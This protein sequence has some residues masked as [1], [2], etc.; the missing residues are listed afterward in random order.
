MKPTRC[1]SNLAKSRRILGV[2]RKLSMPALLI[3]CTTELPFEPPPPATP[4]DPPA[5][6]HPILFSS[7]RDKSVSNALEVIAATA[8]GS[9][10]VN[11]SNHVAND[12][13]PVWSPDGQQIAF[14]SDRNGNYDIYLM[15]RDGS[16]VRQLT[17]D[18]M[19]ERYPAWSPDGTQILFAS[20]R[21]GT[22]AQPQTSRS[23]HTDLFVIEIDGSRTRNLTNTPTSSESRGAW[24]PDGKTIAFIRIGRVMLMNV[25]GTGSRPLHDVDPGFSDDAVAWSPDGKMLAWSAFNINHPFATETYA[26]F[27]AN[28]DGTNVQRITQLGYS[29]ARFPSFSPDGKRIVY[30]RD[31]VD[32]WWGRFRTQN[33]HIMNIDGSNNVQITSDRDARNELGGPQAWTK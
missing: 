29:S 2:I 7:Y 32:E 18:T 31:A 16:D 5:A 33:L 25:D 3:A 6:T 1:H 19:D 28:A 20:G 17:T 13:D 26:I 4:V 12:L 27:T 21:D 30:N 14:V 10:F 11:L 9:D 22:V 8:D 15:K 24:S 23:R